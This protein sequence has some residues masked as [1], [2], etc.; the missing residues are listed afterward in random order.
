MTWFHGLADFVINRIEQVSLLEGSMIESEAKTA[1]QEWNEMIELDLRPHPSLAH[2]ETIGRT[3]TNNP[4]LT[5]AK[6]Y[7]RD[8]T[9]GSLLLVESRLV[10]PTLLDERPDT[11][12]RRLFTEQNILQKRSRHTAMRYADSVKQRLQPLGKAF[13]EAVIQVSDAEYRQLLLLALMIHTPVL[14]DFMQQVLAE[15][16]RVYKPNLASD[17]WDTFLE[18]RTRILPGLSQ[19]SESTLQKSGNNIIRVLVEAGYLDNNRSRRLQPV[20]LLPG[21]KHWLHR[22]HQ[23]AFESI[24]ECTL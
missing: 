12:W 3:L 5:K 15:T 8:L 22:L 13:I 20:Y 9:G 17:A 21:T 11:Q 7:L 18:D 4:E 2:P 16:R 10:A 6:H 1:D 19:L 14:P 23:D 24:M